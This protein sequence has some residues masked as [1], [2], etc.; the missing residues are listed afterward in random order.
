[1]LHNGDRESQNAYH[2]FFLAVQADQGKPFH[3]DW[4]EVGGSVKK[5]NTLWFDDHRSLSAALT[6][7]VLNPPQLPP[8]PPNGSS[9]GQGGSGAGGPID[10]GGAAGAGGALADN[11]A[12][13]DVV[14]QGSSETGQS[15]S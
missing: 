6:G 7:I 1:N 3:L 9:T 4:L 10:P 14:V 15:S 5:A 13:G 11:G 12:N 2:E 8:P